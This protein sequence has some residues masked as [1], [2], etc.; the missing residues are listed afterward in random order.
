MSISRYSHKLPSAIDIISHF[1]PAVG[2]PLICNLLSTFCLFVL[3]SQL[4]HI[5]LLCR[6]RRVVCNFNVILLISGKANLSRKQY[7][8]ATCLLR[9]K[10]RPECG[11]S[12]N[13]EYHNKMA[14]GKDANC[15]SF[16]LHTKRQWPHLHHWRFR[17]DIH[18][19]MHHAQACTDIRDSIRNP[20]D[21]VPLPDIRLR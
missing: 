7:R 20:G 6:S 19:Y 17:Y 11:K 12:C 10:W 8:W 14:W 9:D 21:P 2:L 13:K 16:C 18:F 4:V 5:S 3:F 1:K 15:D